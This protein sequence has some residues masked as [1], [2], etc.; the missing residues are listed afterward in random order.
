M[1]RFLGQ[2]RRKRIEFIEEF[3]AQKTMKKYPDV[4]AL[5]KKNNIEVLYSQRKCKEGDNV[6][7]NVKTNDDEDSVW[8]Q[9]VE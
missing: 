6:V 3:R 9:A 1:R 2:L 7:P 5:V 4:I 8:E